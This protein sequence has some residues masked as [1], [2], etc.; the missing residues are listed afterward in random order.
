MRVFTRST[1]RTYWNREKQAKGPLQAW[2]THVSS[3]ATDWK[4]FAELRRQFGSADQV[5]KCVVFNIGGNK[6]RLIAKVDYKKRF[7]FVKSIMTHAEYDRSDWKVDCGCILADAHIP[8][9]TSK[10]EPRAKVKGK[11]QKK[12]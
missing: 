7:V 12:R 2:H 8:K 11:A 3:H 5:G 4:S 6:W 1:L 10:S 9:R